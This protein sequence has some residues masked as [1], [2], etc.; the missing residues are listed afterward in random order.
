MRKAQA[1]YL[2]YLRGRL[3]TAM[4]RANGTME[5]LL[6]SLELG[7]RWEPD[8]NIAALA[9]AEDLRGVVL[10][11][12][13]RLE[14]FSERY[15]KSLTAS[16][17]AWLGRKGA[18]GRLKEAA[19]YLAEIE[20]DEMVALYEAWE[21]GELAGLK[22]QK[23]HEKYF[24][25]GG[26][27]RMIG[28][29]A[30]AMRV[31]RAAWSQL[32]YAT[33]KPKTKRMKLT[34]RES[35]AYYNKMSAVRDDVHALADANAQESGNYVEVYDADGDIVYVGRPPS[36]L[37][38]AQRRAISIAQRQ[39]RALRADWSHK[40]KT[41]ALTYRVEGTPEQLEAVQAVIVEQPGTSLREA[42][43]VVGVGIS[44]VEVMESNPR[45]EDVLDAVLFDEIWDMPY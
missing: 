40:P 14:E 5:P 17:K 37:D 33:A 27:G 23:S 28:G 13:E 15:E 45:D 41:A 12:A 43:A 24:L 38:V 36:T 16:E 44:E 31:L 2:R 30:G 10:G 1:H 22:N 4:R 35:K 18:L 42:A 8:E 6:M 34:E 20:A 9:A 7:Y 25:R 11:L 3:G 32:F 26:G 29:F 21:E 39:R 19:T